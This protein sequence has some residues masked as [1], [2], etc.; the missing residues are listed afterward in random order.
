MTPTTPPHQS[1]YPLADLRV[2]VD[3][4]HALGLL[5]AAHVHGRQ[6][7][8]DALTAGFDT[9]EHATFMTADRLDPD[10]GVIDAIARAGT[11]ASLTVGPSAGRA[12]A[13]GHTAA[14]AAAHHA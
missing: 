12:P 4:A 6:G 14:E 5:A 1:Q 11:I 7:I 3:Q 13:T 9:L 8:L 2:A 10:Q